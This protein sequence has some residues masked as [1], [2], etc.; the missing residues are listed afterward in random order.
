[1]RYVSKKP[2]YRRLMDL[3]VEKRGSGNQTP[4]V[5]LRFTD[6]YKASININVTKGGL[7]RYIL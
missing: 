3:L 7:S 5:W 1:M 2:Y 4:R 6:A